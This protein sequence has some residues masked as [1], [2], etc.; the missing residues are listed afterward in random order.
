MGLGNVWRFPFTALANGGGAF[1]IP[2]LIVLFL[3]GKPVYYMEMLLGQFSSRGSV[4]VFDFS[5]I[6]RGTS[7]RRLKI[8][9]FLIIFLFL[10][11]GYGQVL[12][13][14]V[15]TTYYATLMALTLRYFVDSFFP[16]LPWSYCRQE[17][18]DKCI[19]SKLK[20]EFIASTNENVKT[21]SAE[22]YFM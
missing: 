3:V 8:Y 18:G 14:G 22:F 7:F 4:K 19:D 13:T 21:T 1:V 16:T 10:G 5:P 20:P 17:W 2:Y 6:M 15:V 11:V 9:K 12:A